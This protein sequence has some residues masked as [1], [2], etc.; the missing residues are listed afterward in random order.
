M[1]TTMYGQRLRG[2]QSRLDK[3]ARQVH[4]YRCF[5]ALGTVTVS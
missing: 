1:V 3:P 4:I 5:N 2:A